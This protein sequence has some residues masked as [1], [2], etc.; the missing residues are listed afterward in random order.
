M[1][2]REKVIYLAGLLDGEGHIRRALTQN[3]RG[4]KRPESQIIF[5]QG[6]YNNGREVCAWIKEEFG[7][8]VSVGG[9]K[10][11][12]PLWRWTLTYGPAERL[13]PELQP[14]LIVKRDQIRRI[15]PGDSEY[16]VYESG[17]K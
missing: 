3:G 7:G 16:L 12:N 9:K 5:V 8:N 17:Y 11:D 6:H 2:R 15:I 13:A 10:T 1:T 14:F 4:E